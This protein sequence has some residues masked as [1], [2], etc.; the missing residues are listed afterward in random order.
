MVELVPEPEL[1]R[2]RGV[3]EIEEV[4]VSHHPPDAVP[5]S[6]GRASDC[7]GSSMPLGQDVRSAT[8]RSPTYLT[9][10]AW[11]VPS[12]RTCERADAK[13]GLK[14]SRRTDSEA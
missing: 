4:V 12:P 2:Q 5:E 3:G 11:A 6:L 7:S 9:R 13:A 1:V 10:G 14:A 8:R